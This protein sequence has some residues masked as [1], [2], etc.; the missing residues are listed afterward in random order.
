MSDSSLHELLAAITPEKKAAILAESVFDTLPKKVALIARRCVVLHW[1]DEMIVKSLLGDI[2]CT[3]SDAR[4]TYEALQA[5]PFVE[6]LPW[7][8]TFHRLTREGLLQ[9]YALTQPEL[10]KLSAKLAAPAYRRRKKK[11]IAFAEAFFCHLIAGETLAAMEL[12]SEAEKYAKKHDD[13][14]YLGGLQKLA[15]EAQQFPFVSPLPKTL[16]RLREQQNLQAKRPSSDYQITDK[17]PTVQLFPQSANP[18]VMVIDDSR[19]VRKIIETCLS[20][21]GFV[22]VSFSDGVEA[23][24]WLTGPYSRVPNLVL[25]DIGLPKMDGYEVAKR[26]KSYPQFSHTAIILLS[27]RDGVIDRLKGHSAGATEY[28]TKPFNSVE[29]IQ[30]VKKYFADWRAGKHLP[31]KR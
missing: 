11:G 3:K 5:L 29:L 16:T 27:R 7:G 31:E 12:F 4:N 18:I 9:S 20:R 14:E 24:R 13:W 19:T 22:V 23:M 17:K 28:L 8:Q 10:F 21:E 1:F 30:T 26:L 25:L 6:S 15:I 2:T